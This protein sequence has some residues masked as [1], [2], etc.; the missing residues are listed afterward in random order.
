MGRIKRLTLALVGTIAT[1][2][3]AAGPASAF[4]PVLRLEEGG[5]LIRTGEHFSA[6]GVDNVSFTIPGGKIVCDAPKG[7][8]AGITGQD[9][10][11]LEPVDRLE[12]KE[13]TG[14]IGSAQPA[15]RPGCTNETPL[16][17][18]VEIFGEGLPWSLAVSFKKKAELKSIES[19][20]FFDMDFEKGAICNFN[21]ALL[22]GKNNQTFPKSPLEVTFTEQ[23]LKLLS[24]S[25]AGCPRT[26]T[27]NL[28]FTAFSG[29]ANGVLEQE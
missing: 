5:E 12:I 27:I 13:T 2:A 10:T 23:K 22:K 1:V 15:T 24:D 9:Q 19:G 20:L 6:T 11:W 8:E 16:G 21:S 3:V 28:S 25:S 18:T 4:K 7:N 14:P 29:P 17:K 26:A